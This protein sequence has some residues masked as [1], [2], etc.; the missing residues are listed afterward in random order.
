MIFVNI[1]P[2]AAPAATTIEEYRSTTAQQDPIDDFLQKQQGTI[3]RGRHPQ[4][5]VIHSIMVHPY[6]LIINFLVVS[7]AQLACVNI[8]CHY[9]Y[10]CMSHPS[11]IT[12]LIFER[13]AL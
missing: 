9:K 4:L 7:M 12:E 13:A 2:S 6:Q 11:T 1:R 8:A 10:V 3:P 5:Y